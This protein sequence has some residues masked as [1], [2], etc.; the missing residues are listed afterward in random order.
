MGTADGS[1]FNLM[2]LMVIIVVAT[3]VIFL[4]IR[5]YEVLFQSGVHRLTLR[6]SR[7]IAEP[8]RRRETSKK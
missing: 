3:V 7:R 2:T 8:A 1:Y 4:A 6:P 5:G